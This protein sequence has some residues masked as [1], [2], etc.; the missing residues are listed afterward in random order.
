MEQVY[1]TQCPVG[2][3]SGQGAGAQI[4]RRSPGY[5]PSGDFR[6]LKLSPFV[7]GTTTLAPAA[8]RYRRD[9]ETA[10][11]VAL[12]SRAR[13]YETEKGPS[14]RPGGHFAHAIRLDADEQAALSWWFAGLW[15]APSWVRS[16]PPPSKNRPPEPIEVGPHILRC[17]PTFLDVAPLAKGLDPEL[18][19][20]L[21]TALAGAAKAGRTLF[22]VAEPGLPP[23][24]AAL[25][26][27]AFPPPL[28]ADLTF[29]TYH[30]TAELLPGFRL[31]GTSPAAKPNL[32]ALTPLGVVVDLAA[33]TFT[34]AVEPAGW[35]K[36]L[37][38]LLIRASPR[39]ASAWDATARRALDDR[40]LSAPEALWSDARL[41][42]L[43]ALDAP[44]SPASPP[45]PRPPSPPPA[46][47][48]EPD[49]GEEES[50]DDIAERMLREFQVEEDEDDPRPPPNPPPQ[51]QA[52]PKAVQPPKAAAPKPAAPSPAPKP[53]A[54]KAPAATAPTTAVGID[55]GTT[56]SVVAYLDR[57]GRPTSV[58]NASG[59][60]L[61]PSVVL[62]E[63]DA[64]V[65]GKEAVAAA[66][67]EPGRVADCVKRD[68]GQ[69]AYHRPI[70]GE[71]LPPEVIS[72]LILKKLK[73][74]A[75]RKIGPI[76][77]AV[78]TVPAYF[79]EARRRATADAGKLAG[80]DVLDILN[81]PT[82]AA[83]AYGHQEGLLEGSESRPLTALVFD[84]G[85]GTFDVSIVEIKGE[86]FRVIATDGD[87]LLGGKDWDE[88]LVQIA[89]TRLL[90][91]TGEDPRDD[92]AILQDLH[93]AA[94]AAK[95]TLSERAKATLYAPLRAGRKKVEITREEFED[96]TA[97]LLG[98]TR[99][100]TEIVALQ[101]GVS[102]AEI[103]K[104]LLVG[105]STRMPMVSRMLEELAGQPPDASLSA[106]EAVAHGAALYAGLLLARR[107]R[108]EDNPG[109]RVIDV[110][111]HSLGVVAIDTATNRKINQVLIPKNTPL[112]KAVAKRFKTF[113]ENQKNVR[114]TVLEGESEQPEACTQVGECIIRD[115]PPGLPAG[116]P[117][118]I[119]YAYAENGR[120]RVQGKLVGH[121][122][123]VKTDFVRV[124]N[125]TQGELMFW[126]ERLGDRSKQVQS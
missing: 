55:L 39:D 11:V 66:A 87:V 54:A 122:A 95:K 38:R 5:P 88:A 15:G 57:Q 75:E 93:Q 102:W 10:E 31:S 81:E 18:L 33:G 27:F 20:R 71:S 77:S 36:A 126:Y 105:G 28:R 121:S 111:S 7:P 34:P 99:A 60:I 62:F 112:P 109:F 98:R 8:L 97:A 91:E 70:N 125:M 44:E 65:V 51:P 63:D 53:A 29:S 59:D 68:M 9:G 32:D 14:G 46:H 94:E 123:A 83:L 90:A 64:V 114:I 43:F 56:Y 49:E 82:A 120:L 30:D 58:V 37:A 79:D 2:Y 124:N 117:V 72:S 89:A 78:I 21:L 47:L 86:S 106:D 45:M 16:D 4:K 25:L 52:P 84:L 35:A 48:P 26:T 12:T 101:A 103:N 42:R 119:R 69:K 118:E 6:H 1:Y 80:I 108:P 13:E 115:L 22:V 67:V 113:K 96:A 107:D 23:D 17:P 104:V 116:S 50:I 74:D 73:A 3:G 41:G 19:A 24:L 76:P 85:G 92:P 61:T 40:S 100:T 110:N